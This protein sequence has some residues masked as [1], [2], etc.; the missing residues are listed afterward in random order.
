MDGSE[1]FRERRCNTGPRRH[2]GRIDPITGDVARHD[3][4]VLAERYL[5]EQV[6]RGVGQQRP[7]ARCQRSQGSRVGAELVDGLGGGAHADHDVCTRVEGCSNG[8]H[9]TGP[10]FGQG[11]HGDDVGI[12]RDG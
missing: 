7:D 6:R 12:R 4:G 10:M 8:I 2:V 1:S 9:A 11:S 3:G 5:A